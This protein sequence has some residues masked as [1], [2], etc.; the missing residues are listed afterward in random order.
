MHLRLLHEGIVDMDDEADEVA[1]MI[2]YHGDHP[3]LHRYGVSLLDRPGEHL[4]AECDDITGD[5]VV[6]GDIKELRKDGQGFFKLSSI[7]QHEFVHRAQV[8]STA[9]SQGDRG[10]RAS[11]RQA[12]SVQGNF[13]IYDPRSVNRVNKGKYYASHRELMA[14]AK[15]Q[16]HRLEH[17]LRDHPDLVNHFDPG[18][19]TKLSVGALSIGDKGLEQWLSAYWDHFMKHFEPEDVDLAR[20][21]YSKYLYAYLKKLPLYSNRFN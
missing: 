3:S 16:V 21:R 18:S 20:K 6:A 13:D 19:L 7:L 4:R 10:L 2:Y 12:R 11:A 9:R 1:S 8:L 17:F 14:H 5:I 15:Q